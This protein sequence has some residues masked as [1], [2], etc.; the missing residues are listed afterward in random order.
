MG[1]LNHHHEIPLGMVINGH[2]AELPIQN[3]STDSDDDSD[4]NT[5]GKKPNQS[6]KKR[7]NLVLYTEIEKDQNNQMLYGGIYQGHL[8]AATRVYLGDE[9]IKPSSPSSSKVILSGIVSFGGGN[10]AFQ[11]ITY[12]FDHKIPITYVPA[13]IGH[14]NPSEKD[15]NLRQYGPIYKWAKDNKSRVTFSPLE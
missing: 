11:E 14:Q 10:I 8:V 9:L 13:N 15:L 12:A 4:T 7:S 1:Y 2:P 5:D 3:D 6:K